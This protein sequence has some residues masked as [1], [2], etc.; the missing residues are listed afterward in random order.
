MRVLVA[1]ANGNTASR[2]ARQLKERGGQPVAMIRDANQRAKF[3]A[4]EVETFVAD[5]EN[6]T[7][8][9]DS[10][11]GAVV[12]AAGSGSKTGP[13]KT[14]LVDEIGAVHLIDS[15][16]DAGIKRFIM[17]SSINAD[18]W[19]EGHKISHYYRAKGIADFYLRQ[20][21]LDYTIVRPGR[22]TDGPG[23]GTVDLAPSLGR[24]GE[25]ARE[26]VAQVIVESLET[27]AAVGKTFD[28][29]EGDTP[30]RE[31]LKALD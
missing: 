22:L 23:R 11:C 12:F 2:V 29:L 27:P 16:M 1:G 5:L 9:E 6:R 14:I 21:A 17:L 28:V 20:T 31:A 24:S 10:G 30:I 19:S 25:I 18:P 4:M 13:D 7:R 15:A 8:L 3:E 26:D